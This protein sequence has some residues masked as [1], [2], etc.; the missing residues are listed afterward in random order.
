MAK[1]INVAPHTCISAS[2]GVKTHLFCP[3][4]PH[5]ITYIWRFCLC[6]AFYFVHVLFFQPLWK[7]KTKWKTELEGFIYRLVI[8]VMNYV[9]AVTVV[10]LWANRSKPTWVLS[11]SLYLSV[12]QA[13]RSIK[14]YAWRFFYLLSLYFFAKS[15][16]FRRNENRIYFWRQ[17]HQHV[18]P[19][20][21]NKTLNLQP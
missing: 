10:L 8:F 19:I 2:N 3:T 17:G 20:W 6:C 16:R 12:K 18:Y 14:S 11:Y 1:K 15:N 4:T 5:N 7:N 9:S 13:S 21:W